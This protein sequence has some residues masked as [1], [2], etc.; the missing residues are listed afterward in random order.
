MESKKDK[1]SVTKYDILNEYNSDKKYSLLILKCNGLEQKLQQISHEANLIKEKTEEILNQTTNQVTDN[2][3][4]NETAS[5][6]DNLNLL[7]MYNQSFRRTTAINVSK[8]SASALQS[9]VES[10]SKTMQWEHVVAKS[11]IRDVN[12]IEKSI[13]TEI[14]DINK[15]GGFEV[16]RKIDL[17]AEQLEYREKS[18]KQLVE[19]TKKL[20]TYYDRSI[21]K[22]GDLISKYDKLPDTEKEKF[23]QSEQY[24]KAAHF[25]EN[26]RIPSAFV[27]I[28]TGLEQMTNNK[29]DKNPILFQLPFQNIV[30]PSIKPS[31]KKAKSIEQQPI[32]KEAEVNQA[33]ERWKLI[34]AHLIKNVP[35][36]L[37]KQ[38]DFK[39]NSVGQEWKMISTTLKRSIKEEVEDH[40][41]NLLPNLTKT[42]RKILSEHP[43]I[44]SLI[45]EIAGFCI[46][47]SNFNVT[48]NKGYINTGLTQ[49]YYDCLSIKPLTQRTV[50]FFGSEDK[51][52]STDELK[53]TKK[54]REEQIASL[55]F[56]SIAQNASLEDLNSLEEEIKNRPSAKDEKDYNVLTK[57]REEKSHDIVNSGHRKT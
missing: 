32:I 14:V 54:Y 15:G 20:N 41:S 24:K 53:E 10:L 36:E 52:V 34:E 33:P 2:F 28:T 40:L 13:D 11:I 12:V 9:K 44:N 50:G 22:I 56:K 16:S 27:Q 38:L 37:I 30:T 17:L 23:N 39:T 1:N 46:R 51:V 48:M 45:T 49:I 35:E 29:V 7:K 43:D 47:E 8:E 3:H 25:I 18:I 42:E 57:I 19:A 5:L 55:L 31:K 21:T 26:G 6:S 4:Q